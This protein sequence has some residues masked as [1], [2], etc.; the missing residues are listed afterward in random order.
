MNTHKF[1]KLNVWQRSIK[2]VS[3]IYEITATFPKEE[4][5]GL[6]DQIRRAA[7]SISLNIAEGSGAGSDAEFSRFLRMSQRSAYEVIA[8][9]EIAINLK[10]ADKSVIDGAIEEVD[11]LSAMLTGLIKSLIAEK[12]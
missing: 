7:V 8:A 12:V 1:R 6:I 2:F 9:L 5:Y 11:Q 10:M 4:K 3:L